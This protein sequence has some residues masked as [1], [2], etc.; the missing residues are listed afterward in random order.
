MLTGPVAA[1]GLLFLVPF[2]SGTGEKSHRRRPI[3]VI[4]LLMAFMI[5]GI[6]IYLGTYSPWSP[7]MGAWSGAPVPT[8]YVKGP[9]RTS[10]RQSCAGR[11]W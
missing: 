4:I 8:Q 1:I 6:L 11:F 2:I 3:S 5:I 7:D 10:R 9:K